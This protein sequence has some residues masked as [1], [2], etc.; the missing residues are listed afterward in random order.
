MGR[1]SRYIRRRDREKDQ[2]RDREARVAQYGR[3]IDTR[4]T[5]SVRAALLEDTSDRHETVA[6]GIGLDDSVQ[7]DARPD[8]LAHRT[9]IAGQRVFVDLGPDA[10]RQ[11]RQPGRGQSLVDRGGA[12]RCAASS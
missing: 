7:L 8:Q 3:L 9:E 10:P 12:H 6:V 2:D 5:Q 1:G 4:D 11:R